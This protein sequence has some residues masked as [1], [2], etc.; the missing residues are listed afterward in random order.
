MKKYYV[1][2]GNMYL[3]EINVDYELLKNNFV[4][5]LE[6][7]YSDRYALKIDEDEKN[8]VIKILERVLKIET[9][10]NYIT[11]EEVKENE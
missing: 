10:S 7:R 6:F 5:S 3:N 4:N 9:L 11:F 8:D 2:L 1:K